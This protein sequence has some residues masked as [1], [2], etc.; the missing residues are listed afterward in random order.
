MEWAALEKAMAPLQQ[1]AALFPAAA[2]RGDL[3]VVLTAARFFGPQLALTGLVAPLLTVRG[4]W[5][6]GCSSCPG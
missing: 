6:L 5:W 4:G 2:L 1:G 3:G